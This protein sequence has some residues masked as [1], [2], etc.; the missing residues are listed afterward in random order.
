MKLNLT[1]LYEE[2]IQLLQEAAEEAA[3][4]V[5]AATT[6]TITTASAAASTRP[7]PP[8]TSMAA[9]DASTSAWVAPSRLTASASAA[10]YQAGWVASLLLM[11][12]LLA[13]YLSLHCFNLK[14]NSQK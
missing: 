1:S 2:R 4:T 11:A 10:C 14:Q 6:E 8:S 13:T 7:P 9:P 12:V 5:A 3:M